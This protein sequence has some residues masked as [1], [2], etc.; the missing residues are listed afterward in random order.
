M[1]R[2]RM[3]GG[4]DGGMTGGMDGH[5]GGQPIYGISKVVKPEPAK[6]DNTTQKSNFP[7]VTIRK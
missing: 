7:E 4:M 1:L 2:G 6:E 3:T 5:M